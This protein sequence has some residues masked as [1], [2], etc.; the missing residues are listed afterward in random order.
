M[1]TMKFRAVVRGTN[2]AGKRLRRVRNVEAPTFELAWASFEAIYADMTKS[3]SDVY[4]T[5]L[6]PSGLRVDGTASV[7]FELS[8]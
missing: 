8:L 7:G 6:P 1:E 2:K 4:P 3:L 5:V